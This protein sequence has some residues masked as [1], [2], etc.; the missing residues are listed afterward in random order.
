[1]VMDDRRARESQG[2]GADVIAVTRLNGERIALNPELIERVEETPDT[3]V[4]LTDGAKYVVA[5]TLD[6]V[7][8]RVVAYR[9]RILVT[10]SLLASRVEEG[11]RVEGVPLRLVRGRGE[12][13]AAPEADADTDPGSGGAPGGLPDA[14]PGE[15]PDA[16]PWARV[17]PVAPLRPGSRS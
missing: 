15:K 2:E 16:G 13:D 14:V 17:E 10:A 7:S 1:M 3:V 6:E 4:T 5:E 11:D 12:T 9:A 8:E